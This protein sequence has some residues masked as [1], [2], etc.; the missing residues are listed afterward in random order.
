MDGS[1][2]RGL[3]TDSLSDLIEHEWTLAMTG[4]GERSITSQLFRFM[5]ARFQGTEWDVDHEY[6]RNI[7]LSK[8]ISFSH[9]DDTGDQRIYPDIIVHKRGSDENL[10]VIEAKK[11]TVTDDNDLDKVRALVTSRDYGYEWGL[12]LTFGIDGPG[13]EAW[14]R[15]PAYIQLWSPTWSWVSFDPQTGQPSFDSLQPVFDA[16]RLTGLNAAGCDRVRLRIG[17]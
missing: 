17:R 2:L 7:D 12:L 15:H 3:V 5:A 1:Q 14:L 8:A 11:G 4:I 16:D 13:W 9:S 10:L 6:N